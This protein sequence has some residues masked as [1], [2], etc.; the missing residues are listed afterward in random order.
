MALHIHSHFSIQNMSEVFV[1]SRQITY[2]RE[3]STM[4]NVKSVYICKRL[5]CQE[6]TDVFLQFTTLIR[7]PIVTTCSC[8]KRA[9][10][11]THVFQIEILKEKWSEN[12]KLLH[13]VFQ[14]VKIQM[15]IEKYRTSRSDL[16]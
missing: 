7:V 13:E 3:S 10:F 11:S 14:I 16:Q 12:F 1:I 8:T 15:K 2:N 6:K 9:A 5:E 4:G